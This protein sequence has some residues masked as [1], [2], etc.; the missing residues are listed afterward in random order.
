MTRLG[1]GAAA[2][3]FGL[4]G[5]REAG[6]EAIAQGDEPWVR[7]L[8]GKKHKQVFDAPDVNDG[9]ALVYAMAYMN[10]VGQTYKLTDKDIGGVVVF[11]HSAIALPFKDEI[12]AKYK[13]GEHFKITDPKTKAPAVRNI[14]N[15]AAAG[16]MMFPDASVDKMMARG[17]IICAC[18]IALT[19]HSGMRASV[20]GVTAEQAKA[21]WTAG[22]IPGVH[23][24]P[25]GV[26]AIGRVQEAGCSYCFGG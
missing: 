10:T 2:L 13:L 17:T 23:I 19:V 21:E 22:I 15:K 12:W 20:A 7:A 5:A 6:A 26:L 16:D 11:R 25:S 24:V 3:S 9:F 8:S 18:N 4:F 1:A 14:F